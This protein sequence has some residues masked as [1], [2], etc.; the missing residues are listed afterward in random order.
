M[1]W[2]LWHLVDRHKMLW[3][4]QNRLLYKCTKGCGAGAGATHFSLSQSW[5]QS[6]SD[7]VAPVALML[8]ASIFQETLELALNDQ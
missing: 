6:H 4:T 1:P 5:S 2:F 8:E 3:S 7:F